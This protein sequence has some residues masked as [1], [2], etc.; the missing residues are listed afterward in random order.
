MKDLATAG[1]NQTS[2]DLVQI[3]CNKTQNHNPLFFRVLVAY[4][5]TKV[6]SMMRCT[7]K[8]HDRG[9]IPVNMFAINLATSGNGKGHSTNIIEEQVINQFKE[10]FL[11][12]TFPEV[13][14]LNLVKIA[15]LRS[16]RKN[17]DLEVEQILVDKEFESL[18]KLAFSFDSG[19]TAAVKQMRHKLL[20][21]DAGSMN[22]E[23]DEIGSNLL[24]NL[25]VL[26]TFLELF[27]VGKI[28]QKLTKN[29]AENTRNEEIDGRTP[30]NMLLFGTP[31]KLLNGSK[32]EDEF[33]AMLETGYARRCL[34]G[35]SRKITKGKERTAEEIY[36]M[37]T[38]DT[39]SDFLSDLSNRLGNLSD[40]VNFSKELTMTKDVS[41]LTIKYKMHCEELSEAMGE[42]EEVKKAEM[43]HRF[44]KA[45][46]LAGTYAFIEGSHEVEEVHFYN[47]VKLVEESGEAFS[48]ILTRERNYVKLANYIAG[49][50]REITHVDLVEDLP[51]YKGSESQ[52]RELMNLAIAH[53]YKNNIIIKKSFNDGIEFLKGESLKEVN[54]DRL[55]LA[56]STDW[57]SEYQAEYAPFDK[58]HKL[59]TLPSHHWVNHHMLDEHRKEDNAIP[60]FDMIV[61]DVDGTED[62]ETAKRLLQDYKFLIHTTISCTQEEHRFRI[63]MPISHRLKMTATDFKEFMSNIY[64][65]LPFEVD[66]QTNQRSRKWA[67]HN[68]NHEYNDGEVLNA[69]EFIPKTSK[70]E[71][72]K[73][74]VHDLQ[75]LNNL[76]R[77]FL[78]NSETGNR[79]NQLIRYALV[80]VDAGKEEEYVELKVKA[81]ND[82]LQDPLD[83]IEI[84][85]T[86]MKT[87]SRAIHKRGV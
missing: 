20:M 84:S 40:I 10:N 27:D 8:T 41:L 33:Y 85:T 49:V 50:S 18:G 60:G 81:L 15:N 80:L 6:A 68:G 61:L 21:A 38:D 87:V 17:I 34:F 29:T 69:L 31:A 37:L 86:I 12:Y 64:E 36:D 73:K 1:Y 5:F 22:M 45:L 13:S 35:Y 74:I 16:A 44:F 52:K 26:T 57:A 48:A 83:L 43:T 56:H 65:W 58:L 75:S 70:N 11:E 30:T 3:L 78:K 62:I 53:G 54:L 76:E 28:K 42:H 47:A 59:V 25:D 39:A 72:R 24:G 4:Y 71:E 9:V 23:I 14:Q 66:S 7:I 63:I 51:F 19:T 82:K 67:T 77:W 2:E 55:T 32:V 79:S 46:K